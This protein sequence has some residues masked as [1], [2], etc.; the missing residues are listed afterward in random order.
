VL[1]FLGEVGYCPAQDARGDLRV[2]DVGAKAAS[3]RAAGR[4]GQQAGVLTRRV[5]ARVVI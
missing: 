2:D 4:P 5:R 3:H 1:P